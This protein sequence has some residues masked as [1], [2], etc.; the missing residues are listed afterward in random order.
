M[1]DRLSNAI[2]RA[3]SWLTLAMVLVTCLVVVLRYGFD[4]GRIWLQESTTWMHAAVFML[5]AAEALRAGAHVRV[6]V[7][8]KDRGPRAQAAIDLAGY[9]LCLLPLCAFLLYSSFGYV[10]DA[11]AVREGSREAGGLSGLYLLKALIP[12]TATLLL[13]QGG[14]AAWGAYRRLRVRA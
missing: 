10:T 2:G 13:L 5:V 6:D 4:I 8:Y 9:L 3:V 12:I 7:Y 1:I 14:S 11:W